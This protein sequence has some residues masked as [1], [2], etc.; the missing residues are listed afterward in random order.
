MKHPPP[1]AVLGHYFAR[2]YPAWADWPASDDTLLTR[3]PDLDTP[4]GLLL[5]ASFGTG[6]SPLQLAPPTGQPD[7]AAA[8]RFVDAVGHTLQRLCERD[9]LASRALDFVYL[10][11]GVS[12]LPPE[13][14]LR[15]RESVHRWL[16]WDN[17]A[18]VTVEC[19]PASVTDRT[20]VALKEL[21]ATRASLVVLSTS[22][23]VLSSSGCGHRSDAHWPAYERLRRAGLPQVNVVLAAGLNGQTEQ[24]WSETVEQ[25][26]AWQPDNV[27][28]LRLLPPDDN[29]HRWPGFPQDRPAV[30]RLV[31]HAVL[32]LLSQGYHMASLTEWVQEPKSERF[33]FRHA[34]FRG[35]E[36]VGVGPSAVGYV[37]G[38]LYQ[39]AVE[40]AQLQSPPS[41]KTWPVA[42]GVKLTARQ[43]LVR[44]LLLCLQE[45]R[46]SLSELRARQRTRELGRLAEQF[47]QLEAAGLVELDDDE[48]CLTSSGQLNV[49]QV[50]TALVRGLAE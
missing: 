37:G 14:L 33:L 34:W 20:A 35:C 22:D 17:A 15:L 23:Q 30:L 47:V 24:T 38:C 4:L 39:N 32:R 44:E 6:W 42:R 9:V 11:G 26:L 31:S 25:V 27:T 1:H 10:S 21:G 29:G 28:V 7:D 8:S 45:G 13:Q 49:D 43:R 19:D 36:L 3:P 18:E 5:N 12:W 16:A 48:L 46:V 2:Q 50:W 41:E 40:E